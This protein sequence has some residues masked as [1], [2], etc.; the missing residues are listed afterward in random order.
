MVFGRVGVADGERI[1]AAT[2]L[3]DVAVGDGV[4]VTGPPRALPWAVVVVPFRQRRR[5]PRIPG[6]VVALPDS[7]T[8]RSR[9]VGAMTVNGRQP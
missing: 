3:D 4:E 2:D 8:R 7:R 1:A 5:E 6:G 9:V